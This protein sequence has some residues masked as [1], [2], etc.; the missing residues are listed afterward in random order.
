VMEFLKKAVMK[1]IEEESTFRLENS[2][3]DVL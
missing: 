3:I 2:L 1:I